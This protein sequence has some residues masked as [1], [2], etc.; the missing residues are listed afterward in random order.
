MPQRSIRC[1]SPKGGGTCS[2]VPNRRDSPRASCPQVTERDRDRPP[3]PRDADGPTNRRHGGAEGLGAAPAVTKVPIFSSR[4]P[5]NTQVLGRQAN[6][7]RTVCRVYS[8]SSAFHLRRGGPPPPPCLT[9]RP[10]VA[11]LRDPGQSP[12]LLFAC[13]VGSLHSDGGRCSCWCRFRVRGA[14]WLVCW[15]CAGCGG[16]CRLRVSGAQ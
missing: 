15:G 5:R 11:P 1:R 4:A 9:F 12:V 6:S 8:R 13:C 3:P 10:V 2:A 14:Q 16:V 7:L